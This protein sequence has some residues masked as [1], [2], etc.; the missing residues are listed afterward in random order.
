MGTGQRVRV[1][2][3]WIDVISGSGNI[4]T[5]AAAAGTRR[6]GERGGAT[7]AFRGTFRPDQTVRPASSGLTLVSRICGEGAEVAGQA[8]LTAA[9]SLLRE[10][11]ASPKSITVLGSY[12]SSLSMP[13]KPGRI[14]RFMKTICLDSSTSSTGM[15]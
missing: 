8:F 15:P 6:R 13:A 1:G 5:I 11:L 2:R 12:R 14:E 4:A 10:S 3:T 7:G 9:T